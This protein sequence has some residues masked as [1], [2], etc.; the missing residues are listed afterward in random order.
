M[1]PAHS[2]RRVFFEPWSLGDVIIAAAILRELEEPVALACH[3]M[4]HPIVRAAFPEKP[5]LELLAVN[6]PYTTRN[7][8]SPFDAGGRAA[9]GVSPNEFTEILSIRGDLRDR[10]AAVRTFPGARV[11]MRG[12]VRFFGRKSALVNLPYAIG[13]LPAANRYRSWAWLAGVPYAQLETTYRRLQANT[14]ENDRVAIHLG[15]QWRSKQY[16]DVVRLREALRERGRVVT[17]LAG[18]QDLLPPGLTEDEILR[19]A[20]ATLVAELRAAGR[21][22]TNDSGPMHLATFLGC[23]TTALV[24]TSPIEEWAPPA[25][26]IVRA[27]QTPRGYRPHRRYMSDEVL[28]GWPSVP[29]IVDEI[30]LP[31]NR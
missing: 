22:V 7:R 30:G 8:A 1:K 20:D 31:S 3:S 11:R 17:I 21:V 15:A 24:R 6:L 23:R 2:G 12:W 4:W 25:T 5:D 14:P 13:L 19:V 28:P 16:P 10:A 9:P 18:P 29:E 26:M 27:A